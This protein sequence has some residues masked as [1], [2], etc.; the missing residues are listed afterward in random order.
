MVWQTQELGE[1][2]GQILEFLWERQGR[3]GETGQA[4]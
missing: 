2:P 4:W 3:A 1:G